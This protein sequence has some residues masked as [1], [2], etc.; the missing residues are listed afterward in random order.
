M[1]YQTLTEQL[2]SG[3]DWMFMSSVKQNIDKFKHNNIAY[4]YFPSRL[5]F[6]TFPPSHPPW[7]IVLGTTFTALVKRTSE[8]KFSQQIM[9][10]SIAQIN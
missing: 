6:H 5:V 7:Y 8:N 2:S 1:V 4:S 9:S 10:P 3:A